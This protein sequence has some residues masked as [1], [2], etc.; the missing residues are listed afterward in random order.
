MDDAPAPHLSPPLRERLWQALHRFYRLTVRPAHDFE[1]DHLRVVLFWLALSFV[2]LSA[3]PWQ[4]LVPAANDREAALSVLMFLIAFL[5]A[6]YALARV[7]RR[8]R[9]Y[10]LAAG[11][12]AS[13]WPPWLRWLGDHTPLLDRSMLGFLR[14]ADPLYR[15]VFW[16]AYGIWFWGVGNLFWLFLQM[17]VTRDLVSAPPDWML[18]DLFYIQLEVGWL[19][20]V[21]EISKALAG[22]EAADRSPQ[23]VRFRRTVLEAAQAT[24]R[25]VRS[26]GWIAAVIVSG[27]LAGNLA[28]V[29]YNDGRWLNPAGSTAVDWAL[30]ASYGLLDGAA[31]VAV[32]WL[33]RQ[34][35][36]VVARQRTAALGFGLQWLGAAWIVW[37]FVTWAILFGFHAPADHPLHY[38]VGSWYDVVGILTVGAMLQGLLFLTYDVCGSHPPFSRFS[39]PEKRLAALLLSN[40]SNADIARELGKSLKTLEGDL[41]KL[42]AA[43]EIWGPDGARKRREFVEIYRSS[44]EAYLR[45][46]HEGAA[47]PEGCAALRI[48]PGQIIAARTA[49]NGGPQAVQTTCWKADPR[50][51]LALS[52][53]LLQGGCARVVLS[54][55]G[56]GRWRAIGGLLAEAGR[57]LELLAGGQAQHPEQLCLDLRQGRLDGRT[58]RLDAASPAAALLAARRDLVRQRS[59]MLHRWREEAGKDQALRD[60]LHG[61]EFLADADHR[62]R[63]RSRNGSRSAAQGRP[64][65]DGSAAALNGR[66]R[67]LRARTEAV[68]ALRAWL[69]GQPSHEA[70][71]VWD[72]RLTLLVQL[73][74]QITDKEQ[75]IV[76]A[77]NRAGAA[78]APQ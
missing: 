10:Q 7:Q 44:I 56:S 27:V 77:L 23:T 57:S 65:E 12:D 13:R 14:Q 21:G 60:A 64:G 29:S 25:L 18:H 39:E 42:Y 1:G 28:I 52:D 50:D 3:R 47:P 69:K 34:R 17:F 71:A 37:P 22:S 48:E 9:L 40:R 63:P 46:R 33:W 68:A 32:V 35:E 36:Q 67:I 59:Q 51:L 15:A 55:G 41:T 54:D 31:L 49:A 2:F 62:P 4:G 61:L 75:Q 16:I 66:E 45:Q 8:S 53:W 72:A 70:Q 43:A 73:D 78:A 26:L 19:L 76:A 58:V 20:A 11:A 6:G 38:T 24:A 5:G 74:A 30:A